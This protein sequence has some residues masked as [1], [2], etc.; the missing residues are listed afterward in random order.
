MKVII[1][2]FTTANG[3]FY[4]QGGS[5]PRRTEYRYISEAVSG[6]NSINGN[7]FKVLSIDHCTQRAILEL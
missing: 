6:I 2:I 5:S 3:I 4:T 1:C 7:F